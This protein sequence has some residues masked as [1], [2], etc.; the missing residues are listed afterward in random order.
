MERRNAVDGA[1]QRD[2]LIRREEKQFKLSTSNQQRGGGIYHPPALTSHAPS[3]APSADVYMMMNTQ[4]V[5]DDL[6]T[7]VGPLCQAEAETAGTSGDV[8]EHNV[9]PEEGQLSTTEV[10]EPHTETQA[11]SDRPCIT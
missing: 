9:V 7:L 11:R 4:P 5:A 3:H 10:P 2:A 6:M 1:R 8:L